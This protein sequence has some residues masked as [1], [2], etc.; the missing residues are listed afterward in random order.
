[1]FSTI[2]VDIMMG[3]DWFLQLAAN[4]H[5]RT[6]RSRSACKQHDPSASVG[7]G[8]LQG[9]LSM[10]GQKERKRS[11]TNLQEAHSDTKSTTSAPQGALVIF[12][13]PRITRQRLQNASE[14]KFTL[15]HWE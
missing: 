9:R 13:W 10:V 12:H 4:Y 15:L 11:V 14:L 5:S 2:P 8:V 1:M 6:L 3:P 7:E